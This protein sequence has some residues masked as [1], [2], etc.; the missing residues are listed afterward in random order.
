MM[1]LPAT[2][3]KVIVH[4]FSSD[5]RAATRVEEAPLPQPGPGEVLLR[6]LYAGVNASDVNM[7]AGARIYAGDAQP[8]LDM[9]FEALGQVVAVGEGVGHVQPGQ[10]VLAMRAGGGFCEY[11]LHPA[12]RVFPVPGPDPRYV[13]VILSGLTAALGLYP[14]GE[15]RPGETVLV[16]AAAGG[17]GQ[18]AVQLARMDDCHVVAT[19]G[20][21]EKAAL[22]RELGASRIINYNEEDVAEVLRRE[23]RHKLDLVYESVGRAMFDAA[24]DNLAVRGRLVV[25]GVISEY[26]D[27]PEMVTA[28]RI[29]LKL[30]V[31]SASV[32][33]MFFNHWFKHVPEQ[34]PRL[35]EGVASGQLKVFIDP[36]EFHGVEAV[37]DAVEHL[38][39]GRSLG[40]VLVRF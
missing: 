25:I 23:Y 13:A 40:K 19:C 14:C 10:H 32:R 7:S 5:F 22:L 34:M 30:L 18:F 24:L 35:I 12:G 37:A 33:G 6:N 11:A 2:Y 28:P 21:E 39:S 3:R 4:T 9:G 15:M 26:L 17:T 29:G 27:T 1:T 8:P 38:H 36:V 20:S 16:T 31:K